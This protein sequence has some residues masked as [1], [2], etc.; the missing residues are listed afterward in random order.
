M[1][2]CCAT[3]KRVAPCSWNDPDGLLAEPAYDLGVLMR[4]WSAP[5]LQADPVRA[6][7]D[8]CAHLSRLTGISPQPIW[9]WVLSSAWP[10]PVA[11]AGRRAPGGPPDAQGCRR[12]DIGLTSRDTKSRGL[13]R[14]A[15]KH[16]KDG[17]PGAAALKA[18]TQ[19]VVTR[20]WCLPPDEGSAASSR[21]VG[22][23]APAEYPPIPTPAAQHAGTMIHRSL[24]AS[25]ASRPGPAAAGRLL[26]GRPPSGATVSVA[27]H[28]ATSATPRL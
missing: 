25:S 22:A 2:G 12:V 5:L 17:P 18:A 10:R 8:R 13:L 16:L 1:C 11:R 6:G 3:T 20:R 28:C 23:V 14:S 24:V 4:G 9:E 26:A 19:P 27:C 21:R 7:R 15:V